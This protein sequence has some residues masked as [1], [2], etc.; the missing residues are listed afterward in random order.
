MRIG[1]TW[2][3]K[4][5]V[6][7]RAANPVV[8]S[9]VRVNSKEVIFSNSGYLVW[10]HIIGA[11]VAQQGDGWMISDKEGRLIVSYEPTTPDAVVDS[12]LGR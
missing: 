3:R 4:S 9:V 11:T 12:L 7:P 6:N 5:Y 2:L 10:P 1:S 8:V